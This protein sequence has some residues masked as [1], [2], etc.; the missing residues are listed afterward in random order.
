MKQTNASANRFARRM[1]YKKLR[2]KEF[3]QKS[4]DNIREIMDNFVRAKGFAQKSMG[5]IR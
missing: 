1:N 5:N 3:A 4:I 2:A